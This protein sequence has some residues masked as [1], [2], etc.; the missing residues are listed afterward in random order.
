MKNRH[1]HTKKISRSGGSRFRWSEEKKGFFFNSDEPAQVS[2]TR[3]RCM[4]GR[5]SASKRKSAQAINDK[6]H[7]ACCWATAAQVSASINDLWH[8]A[9]VG[10]QQR[11]P[12]QASASQRKSTQVVLTCGTG[13]VVGPQTSVVLGLANHV[14]HQIVGEQVATLQRGEMSRQCFQ[15]C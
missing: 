8:G 1:T 10:P 12:A 9:C 13:Y 11:K 4:S 6:W 5:N 2:T 15:K 14:K 7:G 3:A